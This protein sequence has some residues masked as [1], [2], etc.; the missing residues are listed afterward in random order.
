MRYLT[1]NYAPKI[2]NYARIVQYFYAKIF[3]V[4]IFFGLTFIMQNYPFSKR[5]QG[6]ESRFAAKHIEAGHFFLFQAVI[7]YVSSNYY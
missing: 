2:P 1:A 6:K 4:Q 7:G 5:K 3:N